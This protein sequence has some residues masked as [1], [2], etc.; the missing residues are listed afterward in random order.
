[1]NLAGLSR[2]QIKGAKEI[3]VN[4]CAVLVEYAVVHPKKRTARCANPVVGP[5]K[6]PSPFAESFISPPG[7]FAQRDQLGEDV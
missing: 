5:G 2:F 3:L 7:P 6:T 1:V 4:R